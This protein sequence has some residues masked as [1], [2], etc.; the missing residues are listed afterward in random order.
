MGVGEWA[1]M[2]EEASATGVRISS[3]SKAMQV[4]DPTDSSNVNPHG[5]GLLVLFNLGGNM[6]ANWEGMGWQ[7]ATNENLLQG[8][9]SRWYRRAQRQQHLM[10]D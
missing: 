3:S 4:V 7:E 10:G 2:D 5:I 6:V 1:K 8:R 9:R